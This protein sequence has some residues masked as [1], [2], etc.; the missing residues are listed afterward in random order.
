LVL[1]VDGIPSEG[2]KMLVGKGKGPP[3]DEAA[4]S[5]LLENTAVDQYEAT[6]G[7]DGSE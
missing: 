3:V 4:L 5:N 1:V 2:M 7:N 6:K